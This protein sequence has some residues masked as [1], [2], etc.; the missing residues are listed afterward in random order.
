MVRSLG[1]GRVCVQLNPPTAALEIRCLF[2]VR[3]GN[4]ESHRARRRTGISQ[5]LLIKVVPHFASGSLKFNAKRRL[6]HWIPPTP[7]PKLFE[8]RGFFQFF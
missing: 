7:V 5:T 4:S 1:G 3:F 8:G 2:F 6:P